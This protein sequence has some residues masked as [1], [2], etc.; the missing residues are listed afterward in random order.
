MFEFNHIRIET[1]NQ[2]WSNSND[3]RPLWFFWFCVWTKQ[4][5]STSVGP[6]TGAHRGRG[7]R[8]ISVFPSNYLRATANPVTQPVSST[9]TGRRSP[10]LPTPRRGRTRSPPRPSPRAPGPIRRPAGA[11]PPSSRPA[12]FLTSSSGRRCSWWWTRATHANIWTTSWRSARDPRASVCI[13]T[14]KHSGKKVAVKKMDL[15]KQQRRELLFNEVSRT[16][17]DPGAQNQSWDLCIIWINHISIDVWF[18][19]YLKIWCKK[20]SILRKSS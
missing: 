18:G 13:A 6:V 7:P 15:R 5:R 12:G 20:I 14:E 9:S 11:R 19:Q 3:T 16:K 8:R 17:C 1:E 4:G 10:V 2:N